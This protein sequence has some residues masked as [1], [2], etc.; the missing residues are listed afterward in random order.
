M[1]KLT[2]L[3]VVSVLVFSACKKNLEVKDPNPS[4]METTAMAD[5]KLNADFDWKTTR[6]FQIEVTSNTRAVLYIK[7]KEGTV[8]H[9]AMVISGEMYKTSITIPS[10]EKELEFRIAGHS[11]VIPVTTDRISVSF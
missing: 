10:F 5:L 11:R 1:K 7:S 4:P 8:Y 6:D 3:F 2:I 9:K